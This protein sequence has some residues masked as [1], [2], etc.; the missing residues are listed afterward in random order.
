MTKIVSSQPIAGGSNSD[1]DYDAAVREAKSILKQFSTGQMRLGEL[2]DKV[3]PKYGEQTLKRFAGEIGIAP[4]TL[5]RYRSVYRAWADEIPAPGLDSLSYSVARELVPHPDRAKLIH[6]KPNITKRQAREIMREYREPSS[7]ANASSPPAVEEVEVDEKQTRDWQEGLM[8]RARKAIGGAKLHGLWLLP[9]PPDAGLIS[10]VQSV[11]AEW[12]ATLRYLR[13][14]EGWSRA[15][16]EQ[17]RRE[18]DAARA[19]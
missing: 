12:T 13:S 9:Q 17:A 15:E 4:C 2:A 16:L 5:A 7:G 19:A 3:Q 6:D 8:L 10:T 14:I 11:V 18:H 1:I